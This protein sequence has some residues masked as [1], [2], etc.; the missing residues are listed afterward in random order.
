MSVP[1]GLL[2]EPGNPDFASRLA[3]VPE[4]TAIANAKV[5]SDR[6]PC[7]SRSE[8]S[9]VFQIAPHQRFVRSFMSATTPY[10]GLLLFHGLGSGKTCAAMQVAEETFNTLASV[11]IPRRTFIVAAPNL[12]A[13]FKA[14]LFD[15]D[16]LTQ[17]NGVWT[18]PG[19]VAPELLREA[20]PDPR[21][22]E[23]KE[24]IVR[25]LEQAVARR[26]AFVGPDQL[27]N[28]VDKV[29][30]RHAGVVGKSARTRLDKRALTEVFGQRL[31]VIDEAH[32]LRVSGP[33]S[34]KRAWDALRKIAEHA[35]GTKMLL[36][37]ATPVFDTAA[38][39]VSLLNLLL[40]ND[41][42]K[43]LRATQFF[44]ANGQ[45]RDSESATK[46]AKATTGYVSF[47]SSQN[48]EV[49]PFLLMPKQFGYQQPALP[50]PQLP[51]RGEGVGQDAK[52]LDLANVGLSQYQEGVLQALLRHLTTAGKGMGHT[53]LAKTIMAL[54]F[55][56]PGYDP[57]AKQ[58]P[59]A[60]IGNRG[61]LR[62]VKNLSGRGSKRQAA[63]PYVYD[64]A[65]EQ[66][67]GDIFAV[68][69]LREYSAKV[70]RIINEVEGGAGIALVYS[71]YLEAG[72]VPMALSLERAGYVR[73]DG[74][75]LWDSA[76]PAPPA[77][78]GGYILI[79]GERSLSPNNPAAIALATAENNNN[80]ERVKVIVISQAGSQ[81]V[82]LRNIRQ[83]HLIDPWYNLGRAEQI[84]GR[85]RRHCSHIS[86][87]P[88]QR[89]A[90]VY[91]YSTMLRN[92]EEA[93]D[94]YIYNLAAGKAI[95]GGH[96]MRALKEWS[97]DCWLSNEG[98]V[99]KGEM[100]PQVASNGMHTEA[101]TVPAEYSFACDYQAVC[102]FRCGG[103]P[104][105]QPVRPIYSDR[106]IEIAGPPLLAALRSMF[107]T[108]VHYSRN[109]LHAKLGTGT[110]KGM[111]YSPLQIDAAL[112][113]LVTQPE[114]WV[115]NARGVPGHVENIDVQYLFVP[116][117]LDGARLS[118][119]NRLQGAV[120]V[121]QAVEVEAPDVKLGSVRVYTDA[122]DG[123]KLA[124]KIWTRSNREARF[125][126]LPTGQQVIAWSWGA[127]NAMHD[128]NPV[129]R[130]RKVLPN[131]ET[132]EQLVQHIVARDIQLL[133][134][135]S[136]L[137]LLR[138]GVDRKIIGGLGEEV[139]QIFLSSLRGLGGPFVAPPSAKWKGVFVFGD[140]DNNVLE[141]Y[142]A[143]PE[144][145]V[146]RAVPSEVTAFQATR[147]A[148]PPPA[149]VHGVIRP[150]KKQYL[151]FKVVDTRATARQEGWRC[152]QSQ[153][154][155]IMGALNGVIG[156]DK[157]T[158]A[159][160]KG[161]G[162]AREL[163]IDLEL[164]LRWFQGVHKD[165]RQ[166]MYTYEQTLLR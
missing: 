51:L 72:A 126:P 97:V 111:G 166:W 15:A 5:D 164:I 74:P 50:E 35:D 73:R 55:V 52:I 93:P 96:I 4:F 105:G 144:Q 127:T 123:A 62:C 71:Q 1:Q 47:V 119:Q 109:E 100:V 31:Y 8:P 43:A 130:A 63:G 33:G 26:Y 69:N 3:E 143:T 149:L 64:P 6:D 157:F 54:N 28:M 18:M 46:L 154:S 136:K 90:S 58:P 145:V 140:Y 110:D 163:C 112:T 133:P 131:V 104:P 165:D 120:Q 34:S 117:G 84:F 114:Q 24:T 61:L 68:P 107:S 65:I 20:L 102:T 36:L 32:D 75:S 134:M 91:M 40:L 87:P 29:L 44:A 11:G 138:A 70:S 27:A 25:R 152:S 45:L 39:I 7:A 67:Y 129:M 48:T 158:N 82:D 10:R 153:K 60:F 41:G 122:E 86:L 12:Q 156:E 150:H 13:Q 103:K 116:A 42:R 137:A 124:K 66:R 113:A 108:R 80:G 59:D 16:K 101:S 160:T 17:Q 98:Q 115:I 106:M 118:L 79:T 141:Y 85:A 57:A 161:V 88:D 76:G 132:A 81:G 155:R 2:P 148:L 125:I 38:D 23:P 9:A 53:E 37:T 56:Y 14:N 22:V 99:Q 142:M 128:P 95:E 77:E 30:K 135:S 94:Y 21:T 89:N 83:L 121:P 92:R 146:R 147:A 162:S 139:D 159:S 19:C 78:K 151:T 49:F